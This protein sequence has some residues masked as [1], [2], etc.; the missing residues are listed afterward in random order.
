MYKVILY[1][2]LVFISF[3]LQGQFH[4]LKLPK[5][6]PK[7]TETQQLGIT[8]ITISYS[9]PAVRGRDVWNSIIPFDSKPIPWR[10]GAN[11]NTR[12]KFSTD[13]K[14]NGI[15]FPTGSYGFHLIPRREGKW[16]IL[17]ASNDNLWGS[18]YLDPEKEVFAKINVEPESCAFQEN[19]NFSFSD[20]TDSTFVIALQWADK[21]I[22]FTVEVDLNKTVLASLR[23]ELRGINTNRWEAW[24][25]AANWCLQ[26]NTNLEEALS[27][28]KRSIKGGFNGFAANKNI[29]N[30]STKLRLLN[31][32][33]RK[34]EAN[35]VIEEIQSISYQPGDAFNFGNTLLRELNNYT[36]AKDFFVKA[37]QKYPDTW[38]LVAGQ[39]LADYFLGDVKGGIKTLENIMEKAPPQAKS[40]LET[41]I[42]QMQDGTFQY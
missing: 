30:L 3:P 37:A 23:Y 4:N 1:V 25:D 34:E 7:V 35:K 14:I 26:R 41:I 42:K 28:A 21:S 18:Y 12:L 33:N 16:T 17:F 39:G 32:L 5:S 31:A 2:I 36:A 10:A 15:H 9:S 38:F 40:R 29:N 6:S 27:W 8:E 19:M 22:P 20:R 24:N 11:M 13:V